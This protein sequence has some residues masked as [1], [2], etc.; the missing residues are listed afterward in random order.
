[1]NT[2]KIQKKLLSKKIVCFLFGHRIITT[3][4]ITN[5]FK[6]YKC[7]ICNLELTNDEKGN[8]TFLTPKLKGINNALKSFCVKKSLQHI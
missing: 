3:R 8:K 4:N 7:T 6:E 2:I 5:H 1:M